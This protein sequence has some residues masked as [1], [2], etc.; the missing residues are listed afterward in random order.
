MS[1]PEKPRRLTSSTASNALVA[2][3]TLY[4]DIVADQG[5]E[6]QRAQAHVR[7]LELHVANRQREFESLQAAKEKAEE[8]VVQAESK[9]AEHE[10][11]QARV[12]RRLRVVEAAATRVAQNPH[13]K[14][15]VACALGMLEEHLVAGLSLERSLDVVRS[16][17]GLPNVDAV[18]GP[19]P[20]PLGEGPEGGPG[21]RGRDPEGEEA[22]GAGAQQEEG[23]GPARVREGDL[24]VRVNDTRVSW[25]APAAGAVELP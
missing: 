5:E 1:A 16:A 18:A 17:Y 19:A 10:A 6:L 14:I 9:V 21:V 22:P 7:F 13:P 23:Q 20:G 4:T 15:V 2:A 25:P 3:V 8:L 24:E 12:E 11:A